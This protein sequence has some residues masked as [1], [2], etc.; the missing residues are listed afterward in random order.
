LDLKWNEQV[1]IGEKK[2]QKKK[3]RSKQEKSAQKWQ[4]RKSIFFKNWD[5]VRVISDQIGCTEQ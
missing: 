5:K 3:S 4:N 1:F 2:R